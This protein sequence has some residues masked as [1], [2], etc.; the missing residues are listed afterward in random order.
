MEIKVEQQLEVLV[1]SKRMEGVVV[2]VFGKYYI[3]KVNTL[4][5]LGALYC[6]YEQGVDDQPLQVGVT[7]EQAM[8]DYERE[9]KIEQA[10]VDGA[11]VISYL[12]KELEITIRTMAEYKEAEDSNDGSLK[13]SLIEVIN[14]IADCTENED[15]R[16]EEE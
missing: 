11:N 10:I 12:K 2:K 7:V 6:L 3:A 15:M 14:Y 16:V 8:E 5:E 1:G 4:N 9:E 13:R